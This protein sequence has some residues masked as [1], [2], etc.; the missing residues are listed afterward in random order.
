MVIPESFS[1]LLERHDDSE[2]VAALQLFN[3]EGAKVETSEVAAVGCVVVTQEGGHRGAVV[4]LFYFANGA[5]AVSVLVVAVVAL[6]VLSDLSISTDVV[7]N[8]LFQQVLCLGAAVTERGVA[9][10]ALSTAAAG[11]ENI[12]EGGVDLVVGGVAGEASC[13]IAEF[14]SF[15]KFLAGQAATIKIDD[16]CGA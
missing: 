12:A 1:E 10:G 15:E 4:V 5:A 16:S 8:A 7:A 14:A 2:R 13:L 6:I 11:A 3:C 9:V